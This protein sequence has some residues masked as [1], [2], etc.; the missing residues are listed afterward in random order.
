MQTR[1]QRYAKTIYGQIEQLREEDRED[2]LTMTKRLPFLIRS[3]G[4]TQALHFADTRTA[5]SKQLVADLGN[6]I[7]ENNL[8]SQS[9]NS[10]INEYIYLTEKCLTALS[11]YKRIAQSLLEED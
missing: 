9:R 4:L 10:E 3:A 2:Y 8:L 7:S 1:E 11:W 5:G 6:A